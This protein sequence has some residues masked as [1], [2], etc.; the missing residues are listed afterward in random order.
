MGLRLDQYEA[1]RPRE[2][3]P[4]NLDLISGGIE[5]HLDLDWLYSDYSLSWNL[6]LISGG[7][8]TAEQRGKAS[9]F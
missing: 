6:D 3:L 5:T 9:R 7:I 8:E 4:W 1:T 2:Y